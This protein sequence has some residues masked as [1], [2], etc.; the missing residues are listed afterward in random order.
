[1]LLRYILLRADYESYEEEFFNIFMDNVRFVSNYLSRKIRS[2]KVETDGT[3]NMISVSITKESDSCSL[4]SEYV[5]DVKVHL[6]EDSMINYLKMKNEKKRFEYYLSI[7]E[8]GYLIASNYKNIPYKQLLD[9]HQKFRQ[10]GYLNEYLFKSKLLKELGISVKLF[11]SLSSYDYKLN[12]YVFNLKKELLG[13]GVIYQTFPD[14]ILFDKNVRHLVIDDDN[15][16]VTDFLDKPQ[17]VCR[18]SDLCKGI[19]RSEC[20]DENTK[21][22]IYNEK[23]AEKFERLKWK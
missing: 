9:T 23:N 6:S 21:R 7:L 17:F 13:Q 19:I 3:Y 11:H 12:L 2:Y 5:L 14:E 4:K 8:R 1:M 15:L 22:Y 16:I 18:L 10:G 20:V